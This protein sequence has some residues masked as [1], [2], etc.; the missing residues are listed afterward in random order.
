MVPSRVGPQR[1][2]VAVVKRALPRLAGVAL[3][4]AVGVAAC[5]GDDSSS[6]S[7]TSTTRGTVDSSSTS[8]TTQDTTPVTIGII[9]STAEDAASTLVDAWGA[10]DQAAAS[11]CATDDVVTELF[12]V[13]GAGNTWIDQGCDRTDPGVPVCAYSYEGGAAFLTVE[14]SEATGWKVTSL[15]YQAD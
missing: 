1:A 4:L 11:R 6:S 9:C 13:S 15:R 3:V 2:P 7:N 8:S 14:G 12:Q 5:G 10:D